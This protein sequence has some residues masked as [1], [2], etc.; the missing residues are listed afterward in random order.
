AFAGGEPSG[1]ELHVSS[2][3]V[4]FDFSGS[5]VG[6][7]EPKLTGAVSL[8][9]PSLRGF[10]KWTGI[11]INEQGTGLGR[12]SIKGDLEVA[13][14][15]YSFGRAEVELDAIKGTG[16]IV[17][18]N[19]GARPSIHGSLALKDLDLNPYLGPANVEV[20]PAATPGAPATSKDWSD[21]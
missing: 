11:P 14:D 5:G 19:A 2:H 17:Y 3:P 10:A 13:G 20:Q 15:S 16:G 8:V 6:E 7:P 21:A 1:I 9:L 4:D 12:F 18:D